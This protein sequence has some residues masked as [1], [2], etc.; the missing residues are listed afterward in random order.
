MPKFE[1]EKEFKGIDG[2]KAYH[3]ALTLVR[4]LYYIPKE[5]EGI[6]IFH[7]TY[8]KMVKWFDELD[9]ENK[10]KFLKIA[11]EDGAVLE[12]KEIESLFKFAKDENGVPL[13][14]ENINN[15]NAFEI[16]DLILEIACEIIKS[17]V[18]FYQMN[19]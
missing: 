16:N 17:K 14:K 4:S 3:S 7:D 12:L 5:L 13:G 18:F 8:E 19:K 15:L 9:D 1:I 11:V 2:V 6:I 10:R